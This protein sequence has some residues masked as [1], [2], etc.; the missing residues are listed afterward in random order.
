MVL[1]LAFGL[2]AAMPP[3]GASLPKVPAGPGYRG[4]IRNPDGICGLSLFQLRHLVKG[5]AQCTHGPDPV[6]QGVVAG[7]EP[8]PAELDAR[9]GGRTTAVP[10]VGDG[11]TGNRIQAIYAVAQGQT[12]Q[13]ST[14]QSSLQ[15]YAA[16]AETVLE[17]S[18]AQTGGQRQFRWVTT[19]S[20]SSC[21]VS[22]LHVVIPS[23]SDG[24]FDGTIQALQ[25]L[26]YAS[27]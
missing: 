6:P 20:G 12:D 24:G 3:A 22:I 16:D 11:S 21:V 14:I 8:S 18:A 10:C 4:L 7:H 27:S 9:A 2:A 1:V 5:R 19:G 13:F 15:T 26:G 17:N 25:N 23:G